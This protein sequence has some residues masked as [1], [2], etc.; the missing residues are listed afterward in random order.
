MKRCENCGYK[1]PEENTVCE[2]CHQPLKDKYVPQQDFGSDTFGQ[3]EWKP[4]K[5]KGRRQVYLVTGICIVVLLAAAG[6]GGFFLYR[7][8][9]EESYYKQVSFGNEYLDAK[10]YEGARDAFLLALDFNEGNE[11]A[12]IGLYKAYCAMGQYDFALNILQRGQEHTDSRQIRLLLQSYLEGDVGGTTN[13]SETDQSQ[14]DPENFQD[15]EVSF[16]S[17]LLTEM[18]GESYKDYKETYGSGK[19]TEKEDGSLEVVFEDA[20]ITLTFRNTDDSTNI[21]SGRNIPFDDA[22]PE[23]AS[24]SS[25]D[26]IFSNYDGSL[27]IDEVEMMN[28]GNVTR[29]YSEEAGSDILVIQRGDMTLQIACDE[30]GNIT[31]DNPWN[32]VLIPTVAAENDEEETYIWLEGTIIDAVNGE[33]V[34]QT[35]LEFR[36]R[37]TNQSYRATTDDEGNYRIQVPA[38][39]Y[40]CQISKEGYQQETFSAQID[41]QNGQ[42]EQMDEI[43]ISPQLSDQEIRIVLTWGDYPRDLDSHLEG[44]LSDGQGIHVYFGNKMEHDRQGEVC[45]QL[46]LDDTNGRGPETTTIYKGGSYHFWVDDF[47]N[48]GAL[49]ESGAEVKIYIGGQENPITFS[50]PQGEGLVWDVCTIENGQVTEINQIVNS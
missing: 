26:R 20:G 46:D 4:D 34:A 35:E 42:T 48:T 28:G 24:F 14:N 47:G 1:N 36:S 10:D 27:T 17:S 18:N 25:I 33:G 16:N 2:H 43:V 3:E 49:A 32:K 13:L 31:G 9:Q 15:G 30:N 39:S 21:D 37:E 23:S 44:T 5:K 19:I 29:Q 40:E 8:Q 45:A 6:I 41:G 12:Y 11:E 22:V 50:V 7:H 38:G